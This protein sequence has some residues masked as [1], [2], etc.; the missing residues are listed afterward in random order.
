MPVAVLTTRTTRLKVLPSAIN[1][2]PTESP[3]TPLI[4]LK[5]ADDAGPPS[6]PVPA[7]PVPAN[8]AISATLPPPG[9]S[10]ARCTRRLPFSPMYIYCELEST[11]TAR[12][13]V[14]LDGSDILRANRTVYD[15]AEVGS[16]EGSEVV[17]V[18][19]GAQLGRVVGEPVGVTDGLRVGFIEGPIDGVRVGCMDG[20]AVGF[21]LGSFEGDKLGG[22]VGVTEG[23]A[24]GDADG[25]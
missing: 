17:G 25:H 6:P 19:D 21:I 5:V 7:S 9:D 3:H 15:G 10:V 8:T 24:V 12:E 20:A 13:P 22:C 2:L 11:H 16:P 18:G 4:E 23:I 1:T 14:R